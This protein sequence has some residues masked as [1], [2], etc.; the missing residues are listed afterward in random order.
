MKSLNFIKQT[1]RL[2]LII[3][4]ST[5]VATAESLQVDYYGV[6]SS[7]SDTNMLKMAQ[8]VF[9]TQ[10]KSIDSLVIVDKRPDISKTLASLPVLDQNSSRI[11]FYAEIDEEKDLFNQTTWNCKFDAVTP[12]DGITHSK[13]EV[14]ESYYKIL[15][16]AKNSI[17]SLLNEFR[18]PEKN[19]PDADSQNIAENS[20]SNVDVESL[21]GTW[22][23]EPNAD[24]IIILRG[25]R[26]FVIYKN[27]ATMNIRITA[28]KGSGNTIEI[29]QV[30]KSNASFFTELP[31][32]T[33]LAYAQNAEPITWNFRITSQSS[34]EG[35]K[36]TLLP[37]GAG[38]KEGS[39]PAAW[40]K[41]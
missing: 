3:L 19:V 11:A 38:A 4:V 39:E 17:E 25:G 30:G 21:A 8:D 6:V 31:R 9:Y 14:F 26:G 40:T 2:L 20:L 15:V 28:K 12:N 13:S 27:G 7:S 41:K 5:G 23:G 33:A 29:Q 24:K 36:K 32:E 34:L 16:S 22:I 10:L 1:T 18:K 37:D 35:T